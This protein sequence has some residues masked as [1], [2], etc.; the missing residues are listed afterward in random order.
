[1]KSWAELI[2][3]NNTGLGQIRKYKEADGQSVSRKQQQAQVLL[4]H[5]EGNLRNSY[6]ICDLYQSSVGREVRT[7]VSCG[8][9]KSSPAEGLA[10]RTEGR[11][12]RASLM[13]C[14]LNFIRGFEISYS[15][16][17]NTF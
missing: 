3:L 5:P 8:A 2:P 9:S 11:F 16:K 17:K 4:S 7:G 14:N 12:Q 10:G 15:F 6:Q 13:R 1:M